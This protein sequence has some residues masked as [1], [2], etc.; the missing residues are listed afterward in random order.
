M[1]DN[2]GSNMTEVSLSHINPIWSPAAQDWLGNPVLG[3]EPALPSLVSP[4]NPRNYFVIQDGSPI[5]SLEEEKK[6][7]KGAPLY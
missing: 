5:S 1:E 7:K 4:P 6:R 3:R 2:S